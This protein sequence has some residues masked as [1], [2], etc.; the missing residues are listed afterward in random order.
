MSRLAF[1]GHV[2]WVALA[3]VLGD[4]VEP[5]LP[6]TTQCGLSAT[7]KIDRNLNKLVLHEKPTGLSC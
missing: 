4:G 7:K 2:L 5:R 6:S 1:P 3:G